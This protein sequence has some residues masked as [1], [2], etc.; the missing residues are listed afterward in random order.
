MLLAEFQTDKIGEV[1]DSISAVTEQIEETEE[2]RRGVIFTAAGF[3]IFMAVVY[4][5]V[6]FYALN[7]NIKNSISGHMRGCVL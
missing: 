2:T 1:G 7:R 4:V 5:T 3:V 6:G